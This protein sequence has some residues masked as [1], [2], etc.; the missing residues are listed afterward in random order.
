M[1]HRHLLRIL[2][3]LSWFAVAA[4]LSAATLWGQV[5][6][7]MTLE[8][9]RAVYPELRATL[10][11]NTYVLADRVE[12]FQNCPASAVA[13]FV[14]GVVDRVVLTGQP[15]ALRK[16]YGGIEKTLT[17]HFGKPH[18]LG[19]LR[20]WM[21]D[22]ISWLLNPFADPTVAIAEGPISHQWSLSFS[23]ASE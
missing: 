3:A 5:E 4:P 15:E 23:I 13:V 7:G 1:I 10:P 20:E 18:R 11:R 12:Q 8:Q 22:G 17:Q 9:L 6:A 19:V 14:Q 16:C 2:V 21:H